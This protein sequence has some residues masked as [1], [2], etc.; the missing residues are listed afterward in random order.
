MDDVLTSPQGR[1]LTAVVHQ[2]LTEAVQQALLRHRHAGNPIA[3][4]SNGK[5]EWVSA[6]KSLAQFEPPG[7]EVGTSPTTPSSGRA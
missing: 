5:V 2:A 1:E 6:E 4:W 3:I 7:G